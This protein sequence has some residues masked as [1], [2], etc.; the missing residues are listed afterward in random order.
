M[1]KHGLINKL[2][3]SKIIFDI[4]DLHPLV[5]GAKIPTT[6]KDNNTSFTR[7]YIS[8]LTNT[9]KIL[10]GGT[11]VVPISSGICTFAVRIKATSYESLNF[12]VFLYKED[13]SSYISG[14]DFSVTN[15]EFTDYYFS[16]ETNTFFKIELKTELY[17]DIDISKIYIYDGNKEDCLLDFIID[18]DKEQKITTNLLTEFIRYRNNTWTNRITDRATD[19]IEIPESGILTCYGF[20]IIQN[21]T[22]KVYLYNSNKEYVTYTY[23]NLG[24]VVNILEI[25][26]SLY[27]YMVIYNNGIYFSK[28]EGFIC[29]GWYPWIENEELSEKLQ[30]F[31]VAP[32]KLYPSG[33]NKVSLIFKD[34]GFANT[35][36][37]MSYYKKKWFY[38]NIYD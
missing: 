11:D 15:S 22:L 2:D 18:E 14:N 24:L 4:N 19:F 7:I 31:K 17:Q 29:E 5:S 26:T 16:V 25:D 10:L 23:I 13:G 20:Q 38:S 30:N 32:S 36:S 8:T 12:R 27:K 35:G 33:K 28:T 37:I 21:Q 3:K 6:H 34:M 1:M 9:T